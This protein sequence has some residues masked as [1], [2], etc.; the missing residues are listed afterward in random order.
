MSFIGRLLLAA[1]LGLIL[2]SLPAAAQDI[3]IEPIPPHMKPNWTAVPNVS[4]VY[5]APNIPT[6]VFRHGTK[7]YFYW[8]GYLYHGDKANGPWKV[9]NKVPDWFPQIDPSYFKTYKKE[10]AAAP[11][12][13]PAAAPEGLGPAPPEVAPKTPAPAPEKEGTPKPSAAPPKVM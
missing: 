10:G 6:D 5:W 11:S 12:T 7:Y 13:G 1:T 8:G 3:R 4:G 2:L 9:V